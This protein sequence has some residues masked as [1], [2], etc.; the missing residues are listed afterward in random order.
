MIVVVARHEL[1]PEHVA[2]FPEQLAD[3]TR[4]SRRE[5]GVVSFEWARSTEDLAVVYLIEVFRDAAAGQAHVD[6]DHFRRA[7]G[8][9]PGLV[10]APPEIIHVDAP[11][12]GWAPM[13]EVHAE[14]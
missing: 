11:G 2:R 3:F 6:T 5:P 12:D 4:A 8:V 13:T 14:P 1:R 10:A 7:M 9:L